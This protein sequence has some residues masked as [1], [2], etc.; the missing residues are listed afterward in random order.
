[1][2]TA[3][4]TDFPGGAVNQP[5]VFVVILNWNLKED[6]ISC[7]ESVLAGSYARQQVI[8]VDNGSQDGSVS[9]IT[10]HFGEAI[11]LIVNEENLGFARG[12]NV[13]IRHALAQ[14]AD[15]ILVLNNDTVIAPDMV[16]QLMAAASRRADVGILAPTIFYYDQPDRVWRIGDR[17]Y[18]WLP[19]PL[20]VP[21][22]KLKTQEV[23]PVDYVTGCGMLIRRRVFSTI[24]LFNPQYFM[25]Y[26]DADFCRRATK[27]GSVIL[28]VAAARMWHR[29]SHSTQRSVSRQ[30]Y[31]RTRYRVQFY[32]H[33]YSFPSWIY[34][35]LSTPWVI[36]RDLLRGD[37][38]AALACARGFYYGWWPDMA[39]EPV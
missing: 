35:I 6:T 28:C 5:T 34:L 19:F 30:R 4:E 25:Y 18:R 26:E 37:G 27:A 16:E 23:L 11:D 10:S 14:G 8:V 36:L 39:D 1:M 9:A 33:H 21:A 17:H 22:R 12:I 13:G 7:A 15:W 38:Q 24:G 29:V 3:V 20:R 2:I 31:L 32:R